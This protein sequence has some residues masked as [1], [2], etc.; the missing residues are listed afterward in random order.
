MAITAEQRNDVISLLVG[1]F[2]AAPSAALLTGFVASIEGGASTGSI[3]NDM[4][5]TT[6]FQSLYP[7]WLT[8]AEFS[9]NFATNILDGNTNAAAL[10]VGIDYVSGRLADGVSRG[11]VAYEAA[12][13]LND[14][15]TLADV[16][17]GTAAQ[18]FQNKVV[19]AEYFATTKLNAA[20]DF[21]SLQAV[22]AGVDSTS[23][24]VTNQ[25]ILIDAELDSL[26]QNL[27]ANQDNLTGSAGNDGF[28]AWIFDNQ[29][30]AQSGDMIDG[31]AGT[32]TLLAEIGD[33]QNFAISLKTDSVEV[34]QFRV[35]SGFGEDADNDIQDGVGTDS[36]IGAVQIDA[37]DMNGTTAFWG[38]DQRADLV[39]E[40]I[41]AGSNDVT[42]GWRN[43]DSGNVDMEVYFDNIT[44]PGATT[45]GS[46]LYL[47]LMDL[48]GMENNSAPLEDNPY[49]GVSFT[50]DGVTFQ[51]P[52]VTTGVVP[53]AGLTAGYS[54]LVDAINALLTAQGLTS[55]TASLGSSFTA[56]HS[57]SGLSYTGTQIVLTNSGSETLG[58]GGWV[59]AGALPG[60]SNLHTVQSTTAP[61]T[62][63]VLTQT[64]VVFDYV[65]S[66]SKG[67]HFIAGEISQSA[68]GATGSGTPGIQQFDILVQ[69]DSWLDMLASTNNGLEVVNVENDTGFTGELRIDQINDVQTFNAGSMTGDV[70]LTSNLNETSIAKYLD[71]TD[72]ASNPDSDD[73]DFITTGGAG[74]DTLNVGV[75]EA[76]AGHED[77]ELAVN[78]GN[79]DDTVTVQ[80]TTTGAFDGTVGLAGLDATA[81]EWYTNQAA[82][83]NVNVLNVMGGAGNDTLTVQGG[84][85]YLIEG[86]SG[87][88]DIY[89]DN[90]G[91]KQVW[92]LGAAVGEAA[93]YTGAG[94]ERAVDI[95]S[96]AIISQV[97]YGTEVTVNFNGF[98][99]TV[100][101]TS[102]TNYV[103]TQ[104]TINNAIKDAI[105][106]SPV[107]SAWLSYTD[108]PGNVLLINSLVDDVAG[109]TAEPVITLLGTGSAAGGTYNAADVTALAASVKTDIIE[110][111]ATIN[112][113]SADGVI[114]AAMNTA[115]TAMQAHVSA[116][117]VEATTLVGAAS[118][119]DNNSVIHADAGSNNI[120]L[121][122]DV[123]GAANTIVFDTIFT[124]TSIIGFEGDSAALAGNED[125]LDFTAYL[126][127]MTSATGS[128]A[129]AVRIATNLTADAG[130]TANLNSITIIS[131]AEA[132]F[133]TTDTF[134]GLTGAVFLSAI[135]NGGTAYASITD[136]DLDAQTGAGGVANYYSSTG[137]GVVLVENDLNVGEFKVFAVTW[138]DDS[139]SNANDDF[140]TA[141]LLGTLDLGTE[142]ITAV[143][144]TTLSSYA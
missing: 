70:T 19:V 28:T 38:V 136:A 10:Q 129:S 103:G 69:R 100:S 58:T 15:A 105:D 122:S 1:M 3:A 16:D 36:V 82:A 98:E 54:D 120:V 96:D 119:F 112:S 121:A 78:G 81:G 45:S 142:D 71:L 31:G 53:V 109:E 89:V 132:A 57:V 74:N 87:D 59:A 138:D 18:A 4:D 66:G 125:I 111:D 97:L 37:Q 118:T 79:G 24:S 84:G 85:D 130:T 41:Q 134:A 55:V 52:D 88:D 143:A 48:E 80:V 9:T 33:S 25:M 110:G 5:D 107:L 128:A 94:A 14:A 101:V 22:V 60:T 92:V 86:G 144:V 64:D 139:A 20:S 108:G 50:M 30:T 49:V 93:T 73:E 27:T 76:L 2:D 137:E 68:A 141:T 44:A 117:N 43:S 124:K 51:V 17:F 46:Q 67:G 63:T 40:D 32:D 65:G 133:T 83:Q 12:A 72:E 56:I 62:S 113:A 91:A 95:A 7:V 104:L 116:A 29:N 90:T 77:F 140:T 127:G 123:N 106:T 126:T 35:Q 114:A 21:A 102:G 99:S 39:I 34:A 11:D 23:A 47:E 42:I 135:N 131:G 6:E 8:D 26:T 61:T 115:I 75:D 13:F